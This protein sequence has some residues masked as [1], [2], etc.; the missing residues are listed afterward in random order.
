MPSGTTTRQLI[1][2]AAVACI[3]QVG[4]ENVTTRKI[5]EQAGTN[6]ASINYHFRSKDDLLAQVLGMTIQHM[7]EDVVAAI[8]A[9]GEPFEATL[10]SVVFYLVDGSRRFPGISK[11]HLQGAIAGHRHGSISA[12]AMRSVFERLAERAESAFPRKP[13][14]LLRLRLAQMLSSILFVMLAPDFFGLP[15]TYQPI[16]KRSSAALADSYTAAF[17]RT[18]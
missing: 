15:R 2:E 5:A 13:P 16:S 4:I 14:P 18:I 9:E 17:L 10:R 8:E 1:L 7:L 12:R 11:A 3:E 6:V